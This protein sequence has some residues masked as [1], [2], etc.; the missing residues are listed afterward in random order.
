MVKLNR[1][2]KECK[3]V[4]II[5]ATD[6]PLVRVIQPLPSP[7]PETYRWSVWSFRELERKEVKGNDYRKNF[8]EVEEGSS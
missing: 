7:D 2:P 8:K 6:Y 4:M 3:R 5:D 1:Q